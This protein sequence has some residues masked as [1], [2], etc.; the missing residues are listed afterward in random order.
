MQLIMRIED[1]QRYA[2]LEQ[3]IATGIQTFIEVGE[4]LTTIRDERLY[5]EQFGTWEEYLRKR[6]PEIGRRQ[7]DRL[8]G[9]ASVAQDLAPL[10]IEP[11]SESQVRPLVG[12]PPE[13]RREAMQ[14]AQQLA[15]A[16]GREQPTARHVAE[17]A[18]AVRG[19]VVEVAEPKPEPAVGPIGPVYEVNTRAVVR[20]VLETALEQLG[21]VEEQV[22]VSQQELHRLA[23]DFIVVISHLAQTTPSHPLLLNLDHFGETVAAIEKAATTGAP[24][25]IQPIPLWRC[26]QSAREFLDTLYEDPAVSDEQFE[27]WNMDLARANSYVE[28]QV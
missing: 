3:T 18:R 5:R 8:I 24:P 27:R 22:I 11:A 17:A 13:Q 10:G 23:G 12:L 19:E 2:A 15:Q 21:E 14:Q 6:W 1:R 28:G 4:A 7:A 16:A 20:A 9:A 25:A 26:I